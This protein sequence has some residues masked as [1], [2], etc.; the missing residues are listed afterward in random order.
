MGVGALAFPPQL[1]P[2]FTRFTRIL[3]VGNAVF[4]GAETFRFQFA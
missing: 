2:R 1:P 3:D 4:G